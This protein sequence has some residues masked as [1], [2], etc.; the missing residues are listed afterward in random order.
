VYII[1]AF[2]KR[3]EGM[4][5]DKEGCGARFCVGGQRFEVGEGG[6]KER[7]RA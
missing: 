6:E 4:N 5:E 3:V 2:L 7:K 1:Y